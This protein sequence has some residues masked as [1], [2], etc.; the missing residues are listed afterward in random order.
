MIIAV[1]AATPLTTPEVPTV[2]TAVL[3]LLHVPPLR[4]AL[5]VV[6]AQSVLVP[7]IANVAGCV[8]V[9]VTVAVA[10]AASVTVQV[11]VPAA[12][13]VAVAAVPPEGAHE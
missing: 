4:L 13:P 9:A 5:S 10:D 12:R 3:L 8:I 2:A 1:P 7:V 6:V 11:Y